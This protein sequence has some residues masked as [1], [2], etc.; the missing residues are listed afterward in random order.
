MMN[1]I[2]PTRGTIT[3]HSR[4]KLCKYS[5]HSAEQLDASLSAIDYLRGKFPEA[6]QELQY[7]RG[8]VGKF[9]LTGNSQLCPIGQLSDGQKSRVVFAELSLLN[10][11]ILLLDG[12]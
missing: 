4:L 1:E 3:R 12:N 5:Q 10:A 6:S 8:H 2:A 11:T 7:W 9:G